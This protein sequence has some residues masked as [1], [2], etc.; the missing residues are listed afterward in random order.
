VVGALEVDALADRLARLDVPAAQR[1]APARSAPKGSVSRH[2]RAAF[3]ALPQLRASL[4]AVA[5]GPDRLPES[6]II[7]HFP[8]Q[9]WHRPTPLACS[10]TFASFATSSLTGAVRAIIA[11]CGD[12]A[13]RACLS[14]APQAALDGSS[15][16]RKAACSS[17]SGFDRRRFSRARLRSYLSDYAIGW[18][19][20][21]VVMDLR[22]EMSRSSC[23]FN[24]VLRQSYERKPD[25]QVY[26]RCLACDRR[27]DERHSVISGTRLPSPSSCLVFWLNWK[28]T[29][30]ALL[31]GLRLS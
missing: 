2:G 27:S 12:G 14:G 4:K 1:W 18:V 6:A 29:L 20:N 25:L 19:A 17:A 31:V 5:R 16:T 7:R 15:C 8:A 22:K 26:L 30:V 11:P 28:L 9:P 23:V 24:P 13:H 21:K 3:C 10:S